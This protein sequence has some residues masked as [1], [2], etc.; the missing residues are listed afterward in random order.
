MLEY[1]PQ[2]LE[3]DPSGSTNLPNQAKAVT[4]NS[5]AFEV[6]GFG[7]SST[8]GAPSSAR[9][10]QV[11]NQSRDTAQNPLLHWYID[12]DGPWIAKSSI[13]GVS[14]ERQARVLQDS[15]MQFQQGNPYGQRMSSDAGTYPFGAPTSDSG[16]GTR[17]SDGDASVF[18]AD[19]PD[20]DQDGPSFA[21]QLAD[22]QQYPRIGEAVQQR[23]SQINDWSLVPEVAISDD[24]SG[25]GFI[26]PR[27]QRR[28]KTR[29]ELK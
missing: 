18:S 8:Y 4:W 6:H 17:R 5:P 13:S 24:Q 15:H 29:S 2:V 9:Q 26:C 25:K 19:V 28:V 21:G 16:Y 1:P 10:V 22:F 20:R 12:N 23:D 14:E 27:C 7:D 3:I 11:E